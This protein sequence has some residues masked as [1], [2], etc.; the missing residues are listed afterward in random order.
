MVAFLLVIIV[1]TLLFGT[2][3][4]MVVLFAPIL[5]GTVV[6]AILIVVFLFWLA[7]QGF[8][9]VRPVRPL[10]VR[11]KF[12]DKA[13]ELDWANYR[14]R[15]SPE[16]MMRREHERRPATNSGRNLPDIKGVT[17]TDYADYLDWANRRGRW[18]H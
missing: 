8:E 16:G 2:T 12:R 14:G 15:W 1:A 9:A 17:F 3:A 4:G 11:P 5:L 7:A 6:F 18:S 13:D 10:R